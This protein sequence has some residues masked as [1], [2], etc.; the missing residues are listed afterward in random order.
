[1]EPNGGCGVVLPG[2]TVPLQL[3]FSPCP[4]DIGVDCGRPGGA[5]DVLLTLRCFTTL[6]LAC[7]VPKQVSS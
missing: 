6:S 1:M 5:G 3:L 7:P 2:E 4:K